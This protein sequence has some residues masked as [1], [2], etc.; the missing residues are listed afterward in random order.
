M[1]RFFISALALLFFLPLPAHAQ[2]NTIK[3]SV[4]FT[5]DDG[6][7]SPKE[8]EEESQYVYDIC[9]ANAYEKKYFD[10]RCLSGAF[11]IEREKVGPTVTQ[12][13][14]LDKFTTS[15]DAKCANTD[16][17]AGTA[18]QNCIDF[19]KTYHELSSDEENDSYCTCT[20]NL[21]AK[22]F[23]KAPGLDMGLVSMYTTNAMTYC[24]DP[25]RRVKKDAGADTT[26]AKPAAAEVP[27]KSA[28]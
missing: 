21:V 19:Q 13:E 17:I 7:E 20:A 26:P 4:Y 10:C 12:S 18:Y 9:M 27:P 23:T 14:I 11:L 3:D 25:A 1:M 5:M 8:M 15:S 2:D 28:N 24:L 16:E 6:I 22:N